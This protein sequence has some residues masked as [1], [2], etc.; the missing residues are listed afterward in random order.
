MPSISVLMGVYQCGNDTNDL[1]RAVESVLKQSFKDFEFLI[2]DDGSSDAVKHLLD[3]Y[4]AKDSRVRLLRAGNLIRLP[5]KLNACI[6]HARGE[7]FA[8]QDADDLS[9]PNRFEKQ[10][11]FL[12]R[13]P[14]IGFVGCNVTL[15][16]EGKMCGERCFPQM[17]KKEDFL[18]S[19][20]FIHPT[21][22]FRRTAIQL[23][24]GYS[25][26]KWAVLCEDYDLL[27]RLYEKGFYGYNL[28]ERLFIYQISP[29]DYRKRR[30]HH[31]IN[32]AVIRYQRFCALGMMPKSLLY[33][34]KPLIVGLLPHQVLNTLKQRR[35]FKGGDIIGN[36]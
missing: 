36:K 25:Q 9:M 4:A 19:M 26:S 17:P 2:C 7:F 6:H 15:M 10:L 31:R 23:V 11:K 12:K 29:Q 8:R 22:M 14:Q 27:L 21:L 28:S 5:D 16:C 35:T 34:V 32:E 30:Y 1:R 18:F 33:V 3:K 24:G 13:H 20:P